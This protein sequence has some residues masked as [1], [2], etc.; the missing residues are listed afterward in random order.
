MTASGSEHCK[1]PLPSL[2]GKT[3][4][5]YCYREQR[6][7][8]AVIAKGEFP[9]SKSDFGRKLFREHGQFTRQ[10]I[11]AEEKFEA[12]RCRI[13]KELALSL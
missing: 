13:Q 9:G 8:D 4:T 10:L 5:S 1:P 6:R 7:Y 2:L 11:E 12:G 3:S